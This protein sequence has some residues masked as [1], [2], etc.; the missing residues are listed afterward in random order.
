MRGLQTFVSPSIDRGLVQNSKM[1]GAGVS[2]Y[3]FGS[4]GESVGNLR[5]SALGLSEE[6]VELAAGGVE[7]ALL[8][9]RA[10][11]DQRPAVLID[12]VANK[13]FRGALSQTRLFV[14]VADDLSAEKPHIVDVVLDGP[15]RQTGPG[16]VEEEGHEVFHELSAY[17]KILFLAHPTLRPLRKIAAIAAVG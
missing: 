2:I 14:H 8:V 9:F 17:R 11:V 13:L 6:A 4:S 10:V 16:E 5:V 1:Y 7:G 12:H 3:F 15:F